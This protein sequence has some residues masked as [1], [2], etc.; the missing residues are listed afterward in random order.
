MRRLLATL[1]TTG[2]FVH[3]IWSGSA[4]AQTAAD[5]EALQQELRPVQERPQRLQQAERADPGP[6]QPLAP[7]PPPL[8]VPLPAQAPP[9]AGPRPATGRA[10]AWRGAPA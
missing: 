1:V 7:H 2:V 10:P 5:F 9:A 4:L 8:A 3:A 6:Q